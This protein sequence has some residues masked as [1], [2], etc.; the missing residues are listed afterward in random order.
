MLEAALEYALA[1]LPVFPL[2]HAVAG[3]CSCSDPGCTDKAKHPRTRNGLDD[4]STD[5]EVIAAWWRRWPDANIG[6]RTGLPAGLAVL[7]VDPRHGGIAALEQL[8][9]V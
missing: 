9:R 7:D 5:P 8:E 4:A 2:H 3:G 6:I 1:G